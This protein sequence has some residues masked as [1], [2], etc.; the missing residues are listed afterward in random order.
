MALSSG[1]LFTPSEILENTEQMEPCMMLVT[2][3]FTLIDDACEDTVPET[4]LD[5]CKKVYFTCVITLFI[6]KIVL[7][8]WAR[9]SKKK[10]KG[11]PRKE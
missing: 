8:N 5:A 7:K 9:K 10:K 3:N 2:Y 4:F 6:K 11:R 1:K